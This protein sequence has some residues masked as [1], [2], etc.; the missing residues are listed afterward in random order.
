MVRAD[1]LF[2][3]GLGA[4]GVCAKTGAKAGEA[5]NNS[6]TKNFVGLVSDKRIP[7]SVG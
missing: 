6:A 3:A 4:N 7:S 2:G 5:S 1:V